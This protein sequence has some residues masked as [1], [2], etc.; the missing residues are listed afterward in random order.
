MTLK[1]YGVMENEKTMQ[2]NN[3]MSGQS[4]QEQPEKNNNSGDQN[5]KK[6]KRKFNFYYLLFGILLISFFVPFGKDRGNVQKDLSYTKFTAYI[7][8]G[9][10]SELVVYDDNKAKAHIRPESY[11]VV[12]GDRATGEQAKGY[13]TALVPSVD[14]F[15]EFV[16]QVNDKRREEGK[17]QM[18]VPCRVFTGSKCSWV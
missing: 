6:P 7:E 13:L 9:M 10:V 17:P 18:D 15:T 16:Q 4:P 1:T 11:V 5:G 8:Q 12:F 2:T 14:A 3:P